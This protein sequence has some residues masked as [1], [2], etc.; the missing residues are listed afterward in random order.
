MWIGLSSYNATPIPQRQPGVAE[1][2][3]R[4]TCSG[5]KSCAA[6]PA[7]SMGVVIE[8]W[9]DV[10][11]ATTDALHRPLEE[12]VVVPQLLLIQYEA[13]LEA[14][15]QGKRLLTEEELT[16]LRGSVAGLH[17]AARQGRPDAAAAA[18]V[19]ASSFP[20]PTV[21]DAKSANATIARLKEA[22]VMTRIWAIPEESLRRLLIVDSPFDT[23]GQNKSQH[24]WIVA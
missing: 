22:E 15:R 12:Y 23:S 20:T 17:W 7:P 18:S 9:L 4:P 5:M 10:K 14:Q 3:F 8:P 11:K 13:D 6:R 21:G 19:V 24:G 1:P 16:Q 2:P